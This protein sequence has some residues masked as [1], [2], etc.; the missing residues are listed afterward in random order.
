MKLKLKTFKVKS[1][2]VKNIYFSYLRH[3]NGNAEIYFYLFRINIL[4]YINGLKKH[5]EN[6]INF[7]NN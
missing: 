1:D 4:I 7:I 2:T 3:N 6:Y 5:K